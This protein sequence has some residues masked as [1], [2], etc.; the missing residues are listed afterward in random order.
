M[1]NADASETRLSYVDEGAT[2]N[3]TPASPAFQNIRMTDEDFA[4]L[5]NT[6]ISNEIRAD[7]EVSDLV[8]LGISAE[9]GFGFELSHG[10]FNALFEHAL[11]GT[12]AAAATG[13]TTLG[14]TAPDQIT[15]AAGSFLSD[16]F[17]VGD[18]VTLAN[19]A[20]N[21]G[22]YVIETLTDLAITT[23][24]TTLTTEGGNGDETLTAGASDVLKAKLEKKSF[25][26]EKTFETGATDMFFRF[27]GCRTGQL[28]LNFTANDFTTG[29]LAYVGGNGSKGQSILSGATY[30]DA[31]VNPVM[32][33][34]DVANITINGVT[35]TLYVQSFNMSLNNNVRAQQAVGNL[36][37]IGI[38]YGRR[39]ITGS[40]SA[41]LNELGADE[42]YDIFDDHSE[43]SLLWDVTDGTRTYN[44]RLPRL[45]LATAAVPTPGNNQD[46]FL[47]ID[48]QALVDTDAATSI[49]ITK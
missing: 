2:W 47:N 14:T 5:K 35:T 45:K 11:R 24:E 29:R 18:S 21:D 13:A 38:A 36:G 7:G 17:Q 20:T 4:K 1:S 25:T 39:E 31:G 49:L 41:Y 22:T 27:T 16:G 32:T 12:F 8:R 43:A 46:V 26:I 40:I 34:V 10:D 3:T 23:V 42:I 37:A 6:A 9:G 44:F 33:S 28:D 15:R 19:S 48:Y 30:T